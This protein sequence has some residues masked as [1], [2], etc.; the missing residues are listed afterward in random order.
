MTVVLDVSRMDVDE[1]GVKGFLWPLSR[2]EI[3]SVRDVILPLFTDLARGQDET[4]QQI[5]SFRVC[6]G[7]FLNEVTALYQAHAV[8]RR[9]SLSGHDV[10]PPPKSRL[11]GPVSAGTIPHP[12]PESSLIEIGLSDSRTRIRNTLGRMKVY[13]SWNGL[14]IDM[15]RP[16]NWESDVVALRRDGLIDYHARV[17]DRTVQFV[18][19]RNWLPTL[20]SEW[21]QDIGKLAIGSN[22]ADKILNIVRIGFAKGNEE[23]PGY[24]DKSLREWLFVTTSVIQYRLNWLLQRSE[25]LPK[26]LWTGSGGLVWSRIVRNAVR[27]NGGVITGHDHGIGY[28]FL[29]TVLPMLTEFESCDVF[30]SF[31][32]AQAEGLRQ[33]MRTDLLMQSKIPEISAVPGIKRK[34]ASVNSQQSRN[35]NLHARPPKIHRVMYPSSF[36]LGEKTRAIPAMP[37]LVAVDWEARLFSKLGNWGYK[38][39][40]KPHPGSKVLPYP[41]FSRQFDTEILL[42][43]FENTLHKADAFIFSSVHTTILNPAL[44]SGKPIIFVDFKQSDWNPDAYELFSRRC[45]VVKGW[46]DHN[47]R[48]QVD[49]DDLKVAIDE[50]RYLTNSDFYDHYI[51]VGA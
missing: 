29:K 14:S 5:D 51:R 11:I 28:G 38:T 49:W 33:G 25:R 32:K 37:D 18:H 41:G 42:D 12:S 4:N 3:L 17:I 47:N 16:I 39:L 43:P 30:I 19:G 10:I 48:G 9:L 6:L 35:A 36:Y 31:N 20:T 44:A 50:A 40:H 15:L 34:D 46:Y 24:I 13:S 23:L 1:N 21:K 27:R 8:I 7:V 22:M 2:Q 45:R 26:H